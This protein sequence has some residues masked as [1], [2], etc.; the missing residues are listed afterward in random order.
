MLIKFHLRESFILFVW[1]RSEY[2]LPFELTKKSIARIAKA[3]SHKSPGES[4]LNN[5]FVLSRGKPIVFWWPNTNRNTNIIQFSIRENG[6]NT[7]TNN[8]RFQEVTRI[9]IW[10]L[11]FGLKYS[12]DIWIPHY[13]LTSGPVLSCPWPPW[14][15]G[16]PWPRSTTWSP[17]PPWTLTMAK[18]MM[19]RPWGD[20]RL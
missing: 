1:P 5:G 7:N 20:W 2:G 17:W 18:M 14:S 8:I 12:N 10:W 3:A 13:L 6:P 15:P 19:R 11:A 16:P 9:R 4:S